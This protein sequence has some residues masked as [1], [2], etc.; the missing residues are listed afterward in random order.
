VK[1]NQVQQKLIIDTDPGIDDA[2]AIHYAFAHSGLDVLGLTTVFG[3]VF[4]PQATR[5][6]LLLSEQ[7]HYHV[8]V[9]EGAAKPLVQ[10][11]NPPSHHVHGAEGF[12][13]VPVSQS[14]GTAIEM[15]AAE[16]I[17]KTCR[18]HS[19]EIILCPVGPL[20]NI[21]AALIADPALVNHVQKVVIMGG[22]VWAPGNVSTFAEANIWNDPHAADRVFAADWNIDLIGLDVTQKISC[23]DADF[24]SLREA[25][26]DIGGFLHEIS[27]F[28]IKFY[29]SVI[30]QHV[31]LMH[32]PS[33]LVAITDESLFGFQETPLSVVCDGEA[34]GQTVPDDSLS[35]RPVRVAVSADMEKI[36]AR[37]LDIC[38]TADKMKGDRLAGRAT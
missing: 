11:L 19:G 6:A 22:A 3:N 34:V 18:Q 21:A 9:V 37:F 35:R 2:M 8:D 16:Y 17:V 36:K 28:Y 13:D 30:Q 4:V 7:A 10:P 23:D 32:D 25:A 14:R 27:V 5:N 12:G 29:H 38:A 24:A 33:A 20:T 26:P 31:C 15:S 1:D